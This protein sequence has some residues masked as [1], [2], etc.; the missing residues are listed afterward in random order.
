MQQLFHDLCEFWD[1][2]RDDETVSSVRARIARLALACAAFRDDVV[3]CAR[4]RVID[5]SCKCVQ[6][7][8]P[9]V[10]AFHA[11]TRARPRSRW[12]VV[13]Y[14]IAE[15]PPSGSESLGS[16][17]P[18]GVAEALAA[19]SC[20]SV[21]GHVEDT[22]VTHACEMLI[23]SSAAPRASA[24]LPEHLRQRHTRAVLWFVNDI[25]KFCTRASAHARELWKPHVRVQAAIA[26]VL[27][28]H[29]MLF[30]ITFMEF[31]AS[32]EYAR[33]TPRDCAVT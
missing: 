26:R 21:R 32:S 20:V 30:T 23:A 24:L 6:A 25:E 17:E 28:E 5:V 31:H 8:S 13:K 12:C 29:H 27:G 18:Q 11:Y 19:F 16:A 10:E 2:T 15:M 22:R 3:L 4:E 33:L 1:R 9:V 14:A 7:L